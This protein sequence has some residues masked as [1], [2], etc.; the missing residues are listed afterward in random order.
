MEVQ[1]GAA[2]PSRPGMNQAFI[3]IAT[4]GTP[5][6]LEPDHWIVRLLRGA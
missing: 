6:L 1:D 3:V 2:F 5:V 4:E